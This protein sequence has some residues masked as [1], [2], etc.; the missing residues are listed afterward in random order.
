MI[1]NHSVP[2]LSVPAS[3]VTPVKSKSRKNL[4]S[5]GYH[6]SV[7]VE[8]TDL[9]VDTP[10]PFKW[11]NVS[12]VNSDLYRA[13]VLDC[14]AKRTTNH[15]LFYCPNFL[16]PK[17]SRVPAYASY[18]IMAF[19]RRARLLPQHALGNRSLGRAI[20]C[21]ALK[22][23]SLT[24]TET[25]RNCHVVNSPPG[26]IKIWMIPCGPKGFSAEYHLSML[27]NKNYAR[28]TCWG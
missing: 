6:S 13:T 2:V 14:E 15:L 25:A 9:A 11:C 8:A 5:V 7:M 27:P 3:T 17:L 24:F 28:N 19:P 23:R 21:A 12:I 22:G 10:D 18:Y 26:P 20:A 4:I 16:P 1:N